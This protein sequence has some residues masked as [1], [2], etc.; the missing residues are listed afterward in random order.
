M[1]EKTNNYEQLIFQE[2]SVRNEII[3]KI[4]KWMGKSQTV[5]FEV[6]V[7]IDIDNN[8]VYC[9]DNLIIDEDGNL[10]IVEA[11]EYEDS[12]ILFNTEVLNKI[13]K[14]II[15]YPKAGLLFD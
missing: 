15:S 9:F 6:G 1:K 5:G 10:N 11:D 13:Y 3:T 14:A 8:H 7:T 4:K 2:K 12:A